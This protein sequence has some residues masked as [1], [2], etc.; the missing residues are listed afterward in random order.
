MAIKVPVQ[1]STPLE[2]TQLMVLLAGAEKG[3]DVLDEY[4]FIVEGINPVTG[5]EFVEKP[6]QEQLKKELSKL[7][8]SK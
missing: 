3:D 8:F 6:D 5:A 2:V 7:W 1:W 4:P